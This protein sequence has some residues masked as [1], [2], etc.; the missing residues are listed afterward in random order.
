LQSC[1]GGGTRISTPPTA[2][3]PGA[4]SASVRTLSQEPA[5]LQARRPGMQPRSPQRRRSL[6]SSHLT[7][8]RD[9]A[10]P[11]REQPPSALPDIAS[12]AKSPVILQALRRPNAR[13]VFGNEGQGAAS[14]PIRLP[15]QS[16]RPRSELHTRA[17]TAAG[18]RASCAMNGPRAR[19]WIA[20]GSLLLPNRRPASTRACRSARPTA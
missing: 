16:V 2:P 17:N 4:E 8:G 3:P 7:R 20:I 11:R 14:S 18:D 10:D 9:T 1:I 12:L 13:A 19:D 5:G 15:D 6:L